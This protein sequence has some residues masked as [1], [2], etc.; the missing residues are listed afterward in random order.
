M[1]D[2]HEKI[3]EVIN[4][5]RDVIRNKVNEISKGKDLGFLAGMKIIAERRMHQLVK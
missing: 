2:L 5:A 1:I 3:V 4:Q